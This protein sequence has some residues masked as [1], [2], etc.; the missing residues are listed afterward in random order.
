M[1][2]RRRSVF[3]SRLVNTTTD[4]GQP[5]VLDDVRRA[6]LL[7]DEPPG[8]AIPIDEVAAFFGVSAIP[9]RESL[10]IL[11]GEGLV[12][13]TPHVGY[14]VAK[15]SFVEFRE[16][17]DVRQALESSALRGAVAAA[18]AADDERVAQVHRSL[19]RAIDLGDE[20]A[21][22]AESRRF[23]MALIAPSGMHRLLHMYESA[24]NIT[25]PARPMSRVSDSGRSVFYDD[26]DRM[27]AA[28]LARDADALVAESDEHYAHLRDAIALFAADPD[29][30]RS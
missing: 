19:H 26:H 10:K 12:E 11:I 29:V 27:V 16:L 1:S 21:Y 2:A 25:E 24:W 15:L 17:Y 30:F 7:G 22:H 28:F 20:R 6:I 3:T 18:T 23:H 9:V 4:G 5:R 14:R 13:H 8:T